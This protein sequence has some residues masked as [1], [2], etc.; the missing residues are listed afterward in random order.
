MYPMDCKGTI[1][2]EVLSPDLNETAVSAELRIFRKLVS[3]VGSTETGSFL[4]LCSHVL[5]F[6]PL[7]AFPVF[8]VFACSMD[9]WMPTCFFF[10]GSV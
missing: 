2:S 1:S 3:Q 4:P 8:G 5:V 10:F 7:P 6:L 9:F